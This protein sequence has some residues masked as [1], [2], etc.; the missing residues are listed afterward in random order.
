MSHEPPTTNA[1]VFE[2]QS[3]DASLT[4]D[5]L[6]R[7]VAWYRDVL[8]FSVDREYERND[9]LIAVAL[10]AGSVKIL[11]TQDD[12]AKGADRVKGQGFSLRLTTTQDIDGI[13]ERVKRAGGVLET[14]PA[15][16]FGARVFRLRDADGFRLLISSPQRT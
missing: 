11:L 4:V 8:G 9:R 3:L 7:S 10:R 12:G 5:D 16:A 14:E 2:A 6:R 15:D 13:A 1:S